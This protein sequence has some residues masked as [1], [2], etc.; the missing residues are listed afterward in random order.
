LSRAFKGPVADVDAKALVTDL[1]GLAERRVLETV[2]LARRQ[3][4]L[5]VGVDKLPWNDSDVIL[6]ADLSERSDAKFGDANKRFIAGDALGRAA[7]M[8]WVGAMRI[9]PGS[10]ADRAAYWL[11]LWYETRPFG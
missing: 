7:G 4:V 8:G 10:L 9:R 2:G 5:D 3:H 6:A 1:H 11:A